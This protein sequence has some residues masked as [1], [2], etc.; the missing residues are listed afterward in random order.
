MSTLHVRLD[1]FYVAVQK[2]RTPDCLGPM[3]V[4]QGRQVLDACRLARGRGVDPGMALSDARA[5]LP[6]GRF[7]SHDPEHYAARQVAWLD[8][9]RFYTDTIEPNGQHSAYLWLGGH[10]QSAEIASK[11]IL[12]LE[13]LGL[14]ACHGA[15][16]SLKWLAKIASGFSYAPGLAIHVDH[17]KAYLRDLPIHKLDIIS[18]EQQMQLAHLGYSRCGD[19]WLSKQQLQGHFGRDGINIYNAC[20]GRLNSPVRAIYPPGMIAERVYFE[21]SV[22]DLETIERASSDLALKLVKRLA[23]IDSATTKICL[24]CDTDVGT[25]ATYRTYVKPIYA[26]GSARQA[27]MGLLLSHKCINLLC[28]KAEATGLCKASIVQERLFD[29]ADKSGRHKLEV[30][31]STLKSTFGDGAVTLASE[32]AKTRRQRLMEAWKNATGWR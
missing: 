15:L 19:L 25:V 24:K 22:N 9:C 10:P 29:I 1:G 17:P 7:I 31:M 16:C 32:A 20:L 30:A 11:L 18:K 12:E 14:G 23:Q 28:I 4:V 3:V 5:I 6:D 8:L 2:E 27:I 26:V 13:G 21:S